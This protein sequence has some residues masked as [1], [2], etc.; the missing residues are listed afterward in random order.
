M[1]LVKFLDITEATEESKRMGHVFNAAK[2]AF[3][4]LP[5]EIQDD[6]ERWQSMNWI[7]GPLEQS[8]KARDEKAQTL[9]RAFEPV[10][11]ILKQTVGN[12][13][14][15]HRGEDLE[16]NEREKFLWSWT[17]DPR[18]AKQFARDPEMSVYGHYELES[19]INQY[20]RTGFVKAFGHTYVR[21]KK[22]PRYANVWKGRE[23]ITGIG[24]VEEALRQEN[25][26]RMDWNR[27]TKSGRVR[28][29][30]IPVDNIVWITNQYN[31]KE[32][33]VA[34][35]PMQQLQDDKGGLGTAPVTGAPQGVD[36][37]GY[38]SVDVM[39]YQEE[40]RIP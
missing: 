17:L 31:L 9:L 11:Q 38:G 39:P 24:D 16:G 35:S 28:T 20:K 19:L 21:D 8:L 4:S 36:A 18:V 22:D 1:K 25:Q 29:E 23:H 34:N 6:L 15:L 2:K 10:R 5:P 33:I 37:R 27:E 14:T 13:I 30:E 7:G 12:Y 26:D 40:D 32:F 3:E